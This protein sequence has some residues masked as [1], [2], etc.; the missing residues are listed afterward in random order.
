MNNSS[1][2]ITRSS[3]INIS[4]SDNP[5]SPTTGFVTSING[6]ELLVSEGLFDHISN[7]LGCAVDEGLEL[8]MPSEL[9]GIED[10]VG[11]DK[12]EDLQ[13]LVYYYLT[14]IPDLETYNN[15]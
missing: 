2:H 15:N 9:M 5:I 4:G 13:F 12:D 1:Q 7:S 14:F 11:H 3:K 6:D 8:N 10:F